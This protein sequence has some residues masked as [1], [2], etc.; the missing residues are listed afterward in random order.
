MPIP[1][2]AVYFSQI[3]AELNNGTGGSYPISGSMPLNDATFRSRLTNTSQN[4]S[5]NIGAIKGN[6]YQR[7]TIATNTSNYNIYNALAGTGW[8]GLAKGSVD[9]IVNGG[10]I[11]SS[12]GTGGYAMDTGGPWPGPSSINLYNYG[13]IVGAGGYGGNGG[14]G[15]PPG[16]G[17]PGTD[18]GWGAAGGP[19]LRAQRALY[20]VNGGQ[21]AGGGG[22]GGGGTGEFV[23]ADPFIGAPASTRGG[24]G[25]GGGAS[26]AV[27]TAYGGGYGLGNGSPSPRPGTAGGN[28]GW[29]T[30]GAGGAG[31]GPAPGANPGGPGGGWGSAGAAGR[32][33][34]P[35]PAPSSPVPQGGA[36]GISIQG[37]S[38]VTAA[39]SGTVYGS[40]S[41]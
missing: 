26:N 35:L 25:G 29:A 36:G 8:N 20:L 9:L 1:T 16:N 37:W 32:A 23:S 6:A 4:A 31:G 21:I 22:G 40:V 34:G 27:A 17:G 38:V 12:S 2:G 14:D 33:R 18:G 15:A 10:V 5:L 28:G 19:G 11:V 39:P 3:R 41:G 30:A 7:F 24:G 13:Y